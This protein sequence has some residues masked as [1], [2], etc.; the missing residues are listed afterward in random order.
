VSGFTHVVGYLNLVAFTGLGA[1]ALRQWFVRR[2]RA[3]LWAA[4]A[5][6]A[7]AVVVLAGQ[8]IPDEPDSRLEVRAAAANIAVLVLFPYL[9]YRFMRTFSE[10]R[11]WPDPVIP[12]LTVGLVAWSLALPALPEEGEP[13]PTWF[14]VYLG[15]F[16]AHWTL[17]TVVVSV[18]LWRAGRGQPSVARRRMR[19]LA[20]ASA[21]ITIAIFFA[22]AGAE[23]G[24]TLDAVTSLLVLGSAAAF[25]VGLVPP[26]IVRIAW[27]IPEQRRFQ[28][29]LGRLMGAAD[30][31]EVAEGVLPAMARLVG[32][33]AVALLDAEGR[34]V[35]AHGTSDEMQTS[36]DGDALRLDV[37]GG[38]L[39]VWHNPYA[40]FFGTE[41]HRL[42]DALTALTGLAL[43]RA[44]L[45]AQERDA[46][47]ALERADELKTRFVA[48]AAHELRAPVA[49]IHG[50]V[51]TLDRLADRLTDE[52]R[53]DLRHLL[54]SQTERLR[55][56]IEQLLDLTRL[57]AEVVAIRPERFSVRPRIESLAEGVAGREAEIRIDVDPELEAVADPEAFDRVLSNLLVNAL[58]HGEPPVVVTAEMRDRHFRVAVEDRGRGVPPAFIPELFERFSRS[59]ISE[60]TTEGTGLGLAIARSYAQ[61]HGGDLLYQPAEPT[62]ARFELVLPRT[63]NANRKG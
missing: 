41:E 56:L 54:R 13:R 15:L 38:S 34:V 55:L 57:E 25:L 12:V 39:V 52:Q 26:S 18:R 11:G 9:L 60:E 59:A 62:G 47:E 23:E 35:G 1:A 19:M 28:D 4:L 51:E 2:D 27:R 46:R 7:L 20:A 32:A 44:R 45:F 5:F 40:P 42:L 17:L 31:K 29:A 24:S 43:D 21:G 49:G 63:A 3:S 37:A 50:T 58:R 48:L 8:V 14:L 6:G 61:A 30:P 36:L 10:R 33:R 16:L 53:G 22:A